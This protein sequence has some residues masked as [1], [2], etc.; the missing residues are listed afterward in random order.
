[1]EKLLY[2]LSIMLA[3]MLCICGVLV[4]SAPYPADV[5][6]NPVHYKRF[7]R[8]RPSPNHPELEIYEV[9]EVYVVRRPTPRPREVRRLTDKDMDLRIRCD[10]EPT[11]PECTKFSSTPNIITDSHSSPTTT[12][13]KATT[14]IGTTSTIATSST[15]LPLLPELPQELPETTVPSEEKDY[16]LGFDDTYDFEGDDE[17]DNEDIAGS[18]DADAEK[19]PD[20]ADYFNLGGSIG[21]NDLTK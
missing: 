18:T 13:T 21:G 3:A 1:M 10:F 4:E 6:A 7:L 17:E 11:L 2:V 5:P 15:E 14:T 19:N 9:R 8:R 12:T 16:A 20:A